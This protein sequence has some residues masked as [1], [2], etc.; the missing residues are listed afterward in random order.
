[1]KEGKSVRVIVERFRQGEDILERLGELARQNHANAGTFVGIGAVEKASVGF[2]RGDGQYSTVSLEGPLEVL[3]CVGNVA[4]KEGI[5]IIHAH[6]SLADREGRA[7][8][9]HLMLGCTVD[10]T[11]EVSL[12]IYDE[13]QLIRKLD[14]ATKLFLLET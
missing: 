14:S 2:F 9:G 10:A 13:V 8:G 5:P 7:Y 6:I 3:S 12:Y 4:L 1:M 11:F